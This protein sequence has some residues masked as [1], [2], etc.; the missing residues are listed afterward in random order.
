[1]TDR[2]VVRDEDLPAIER[3]LRERIRQRG[4]AIEGMAGY[5]PQVAPDEA[6]GFA[7]AYLQHVSRG[8]PDGTRR[9][10]DKLPHNFFRLALI[11][12]LFPRGR[13]IHVRRDPL[14]TCL[15]CYFQ[16]FTVGHPWSYD[17]A[18]TGRFYRLYERIV[19]LH[20]E[21]SPLAITDV[22]YEDLVADPEAETRRL[23]AFLGLDWDPACLGGDR[24]TRTIRTASAWQARQPVYRSSVAKSERYAAHL[25]PLREALARDPVEG[26]AMMTP[27]SVDGTTAAGRVR[28][29]D[30]AAP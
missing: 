30:P 20:R 11:A 13:V 6:R 26:A 9:I 24:G 25:G 2:M 17:L 14:D 4:G 28:A 1:M 7:Q 22:N 23:V 21:H 3:T 10:V 12:L 15:S 8:L 27:A 18:A 29:A 16:N 19:A 5:L